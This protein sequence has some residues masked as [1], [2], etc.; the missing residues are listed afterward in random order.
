MRT[1]SLA[2]LLCTAAAAIVSA[3]SLASR[4]TASDGTVQVIYPSRPSACGD[5]QNYIADVFGHSTYYNGGSGISSTN[6]RSDRPCVHGPARITATVI[7]GEVTR[8]RANVG[9]PPASA[10]EDRSMT[11]STADASAWL[12][13]L[14]NHGSARIAS[15]AML[16]L[17]LVDG[18]EPWSMLL[19]IARNDARPLAT[20]RASLT[21]L[22]MGVTDHLGLSDQGDDSDN[23]EVKKQAVFALFQRPKS[24]SVPELIDIV[25]TVK[26]PAVRRSAIFWLGQTGDMR[27]IDLYA[28]L[29]KQ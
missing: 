10:R 1:L 2:A 28:D 20:R 6:W 14:I 29:L 5:G 8:L 15:D 3:Q 17:V 21:W 27:A 11:V 18:P 24:E 22:A 9:P 13:D 7:H 16:P 25:R 19:Q 23:D 26:N 4:V 12:G